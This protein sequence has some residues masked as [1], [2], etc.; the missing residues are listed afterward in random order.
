MLI[1]G[2]PITEPDGQTQLDD[3]DLGAIERIEVLRG[4]A[5][6][7]YGNAAGGVIQFFTEDAPPVPTAEA[8][9]T[10]GSYG[11]GKYQL[12]GG[13]RTEKAQ[14]VPRRLVSAARRLSRPQRDAGRQLHRQAALR[15]QRRD[16]RHAACSP[17]SIRRSRRI[18]AR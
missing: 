16:R 2:L 11:F 9:L 13:G 17:P 7:L 18:P 10:G 12:K 14:V 3:L 15:R 5:G 1:D 4:P 6:A 8:I